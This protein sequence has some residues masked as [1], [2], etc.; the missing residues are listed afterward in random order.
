MQLID[1]SVNEVNALLILIGQE[2]TPFLL[3]TKN[4][5]FIKM[6]HS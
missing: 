5:I 3:S 2:L 6:M 4:I 1:C